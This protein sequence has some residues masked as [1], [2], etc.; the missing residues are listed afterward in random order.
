M[1]FTLLS[2]SSNTISVITLN[3]LISILFMS[4]LSTYCFFKK[5]NDFK[6][7][8]EIKAKLID[9]YIQR[10]FKELTR[11]SNIVF[12]EKKASR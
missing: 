1:P 2:G 5:E 10:I 11:L 7:D 12:E 8:N 9:Y 4:A 6:N 3:L